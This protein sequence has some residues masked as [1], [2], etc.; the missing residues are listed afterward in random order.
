MLGRLDLLYTAHVPRGDGPFPTVLTLHGWGASAH[1]LLGLAPLLH[2][3][4][5]LV[6]CPEG[7]ESTP[8]GPGMTGHGWYPIAR[9]EAPDRDDFE[10][11]GVALR[12]FLEE[13][14]HR[15]PIDPDKLVVM[16]FSQGGVMAYDLFLSE[17]ARFAGLIALSSWLPPHVAEASPRSDELAGRPV[18][19]MHGTRDP[20]IDVERGRESRKLL[21]ERG[22]ALAYREYEMGHEIAPEALRDLV[23]WL[24]DKVLSPILLV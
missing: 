11:G 8:I 18:L 15:Y 24:D 7:P 14:A 16:G 19:V 17:P 5:A 21:I 23:A 6:L 13:A 4:D 2:A 1:D 12:S 10:R 3:G 9:G 22:V 20:L